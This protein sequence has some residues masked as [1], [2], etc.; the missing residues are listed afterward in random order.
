MSDVFY[1]GGGKK[2]LDVFFFAKE[3]VDECWGV[4][5]WPSEQLFLQ[6]STGLLVIFSYN[7]MSRV[8]I[9]KKVPADFLQTSYGLPV[10]FPDFT[11][12]A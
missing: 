9:E 5:W 6:L 1:G 3:A 8:T 10:D 7:T 2:Q 4:R 12:F 11:S